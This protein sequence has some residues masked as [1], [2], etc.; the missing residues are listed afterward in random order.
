MTSEDARLVTTNTQAAGDRRPALSP[1]VDYPSAY[2]ATKQVGKYSRAE[3]RHRWRTHPEE[4]PAI[5]VYAVYNGWMPAPEGSYLQ[6]LYPHTYRIRNGDTIE[7]LA[8]KNCH[9]PTR[10]EEP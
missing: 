8:A 10:K 2:F 5:L 1:N 4:R 7:D 6:R 9:H 3:L